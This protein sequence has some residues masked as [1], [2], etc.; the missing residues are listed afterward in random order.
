MLESQKAGDEARKGRV[1]EEGAH[2]KDRRGLTKRKK[3]GLLRKGALEGQK[4]G[5]HE[6]KGRVATEGVFGR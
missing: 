4:A 6:M 3:E 2:L 1:D 5:D